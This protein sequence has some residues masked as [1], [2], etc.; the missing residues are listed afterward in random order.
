MISERITDRSDS[1][2]DP[3]R[4]L[5]GQSVRSDGTFVAES[6]LVLERI[7]Q[8]NIG[9]RAI[10]ISP[11]RAERLQDF[12]AHNVDRARNEISV[13]VAER[14][15]ID[16]V[17]GY[18]LNRG[19]IVLADR[20]ALP[21]AEEVLGGAK[22]VVALEGVMDPDNVGTMF[23]HSAGF[24]V[25]A[26]LLHR[27]TGDPLYRKTIRTSMGWSIEIP[28]AHTSSGSNLPDVLNGAGFV[29]LAL[30]PDPTAEVLSD[31]LGELSDTQPLAL[32][33]GAEG[34]G[35]EP[36]TLA[37]ATRRVRIPLSDGVDSLNVSTA[38]AI[39]L[40]ALSVA[41]PARLQ[42]RTGRSG[43]SRS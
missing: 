28:Y 43:L 8:A 25:D 40:Y 2:L 24:G 3:F 32:M 6:E 23:R 5:K 1:R 29:S 14:D 17:V 18:P 11:P 30:T 38:G 31:V 9:V 20:P 13:Y 26:V 22:T 36:D 42:G 21:S 35:L 19:V 37:A 34:P 27:K 15:L 4:N 33:L 16:S 41:H 10:L 39:A 7:F 12:I